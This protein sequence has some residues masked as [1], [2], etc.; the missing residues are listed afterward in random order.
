MRLV[1]AVLML[2]LIGCATT[3]K[4]KEPTVVELVTSK[5]KKTAIADISK[6]LI[7]KGFTIKS[8][9][10]DGGIIVTEPSPFYFKY[11][12]MQITYPGRSTAQVAVTND[13][14]KVTITHECGGMNVVSGSGI[15]F[16]KCEKSVA[17]KETSEKEKEFL[18]AVRSA[19]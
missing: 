4:P 16:V 13:R 15:S 10:H 8:T 2:T 17:V 3:P 19:L 1:A 5:D 14:V 18:E 6:S 11:S 12:F 7:D 9:D